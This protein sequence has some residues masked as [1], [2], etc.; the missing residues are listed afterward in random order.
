MKADD[1]SLGQLMARA[2]DGDRAAYTALLEQAQRWLKRYYARRVPPHALDDL[3]QETL[4]SLHR[5]RA[6]YDPARPFLPWLAAIARF[7]WVDHLRRVY[8][9]DETELPADISVADEGDAIAAKVSLEKLLG[10]IPPGQAAAIR[11]VKIDGLKR[12]AAMIE[13]E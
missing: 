6:S 3:V 13:S 5:K 1:L 8:R 12:M 2:Q 11:L 4:V 10:L 9:A 7:R